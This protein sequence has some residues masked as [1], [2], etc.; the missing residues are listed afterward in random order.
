VNVALSSGHSAKCRGAAGY[1]DE[2]DQARIVTDRVAQ[3]LENVGVGASVFHDNTSTTQDTN[4]KTIVSAHNAKQRDVDCSIHFNCYDGTASGT[5]CLYMTEE[6]LAAEVAAGIAKAGGFK[7][8]GPKHR[9]DLYFLRHTEMPAILVE[10]CFVDS[11]EDVDLYHANLEAICGGLA[12][13]LSG[14]DQPVTVT[15]QP[16]EPEAKPEPPEPATKNLLGK[17]EGCEIWQ[18]FQGGRERVEWTAKMAVCCDGMP[19]NTYGDDYWQRGTAYYSNT[20][21]NGYLNGDT[22]P[23]IVIP[24]LIRS[25]T[26][27]VVMGCQGVI[28]NTDNGENT[29]AIC[30]EIGPDDKLGEA[31]CEGARRVGLDGNPNH[32]GTDNKIIKYVI[33]TDVPATVDGITYK[34]QPA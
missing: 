10:V 25:K 15:D 12:A 33:W 34:L 22:V 17:I 30:G 29:P 13:A 18:I 5:E 2:V 26:K 21:N 31:S 1:I 28:S 14:K 23:Y 32:G 16:A 9:D 4:L 7:N 20:T 8:R 27:G 24:P 19:K 11:Q 3:L 6:D